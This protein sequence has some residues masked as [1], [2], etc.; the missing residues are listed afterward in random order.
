MDD[1]WFF[2]RFARLYD[3]VMWTANREPIEA[4]FDQAMIEIETVIDLAGGTGRFARTLT[5]VYDVTVVDLSRPMLANA[6]DY[7]IEC[8]QGDATSLPVPA[9]AVDAIIIADAYHHFPDPGAVLDEVTRALRPGGVVVVREFN[10]TT[11]RGGLVVMAE[12]ALGWPAEF[13]IP[14]QLASDLTAHGFEARIVDDGFGY[15]AVGR[16]PKSDR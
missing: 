10:T 15:T 2:D 9:D 8:V 7:G 1:D 12:R 6:R 16:K 3:A 13:R 14:G 11:L 5:G 4:G